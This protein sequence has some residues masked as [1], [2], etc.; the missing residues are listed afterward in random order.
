[1]V[2]LLRRLLCAVQDQA[3]VDSMAPTS[4]AGSIQPKVSQSLRE[5]RFVLYKA[6]KQR[7]EC[8]QYRPLERGL[9]SLLMSGPIES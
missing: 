7:L 5:S 9:I 4:L 8:R 1:M 2:A 6:R 3:D